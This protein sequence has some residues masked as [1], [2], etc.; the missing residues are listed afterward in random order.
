MFPIVLLIQ[1]SVFKNST[2]DDD[3]GV[4][5]AK[6]KLVILTSHI[7][8]STAAVTDDVVSLAV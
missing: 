7:D 8:L 5:N 4:D 6:T 3:A 2:N 1:P